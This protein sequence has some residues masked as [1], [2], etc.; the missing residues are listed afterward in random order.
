M[1]IA[2]VLVWV[3]AVA[4]IVQT[5]VYYPQL[6]DIVASHFDGNG[7]PN[8]WSSKTEFFVIYFGALVLTLIIFVVLP[9][10]SANRKPASFKVP[11]RNYWFHPD[12][13]EATV[14]F[15]KNQFLWLGVVHILLAFIV[16]HVVIQANLVENPILSNGIYWVLGVYGLFVVLWLACFVFKFYRRPRL[17]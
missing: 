4:A 6:P 3:L 14:R 9:K 16:I 8:G 1:K 7:V 17:D 10:V 11:T 13:V 12:R 2:M 15:I 5:I